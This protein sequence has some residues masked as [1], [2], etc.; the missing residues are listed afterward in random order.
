MPRR[1]ITRICDRCG[2]EYTGFGKKFCSISCSSKSF[3]SIKER[4]WLKV[5]VEGLFNC[6]EWIGAKNSDGYGN[7]GFNNKTLNSSKVVWLLIYCSYYANSKV[8]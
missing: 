6:W 2:K 8:I 1:K 4:F 3:L 5:R 7:F